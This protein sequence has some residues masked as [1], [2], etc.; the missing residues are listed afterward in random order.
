MTLEEL[1]KIIGQQTSNLQLKMP[2]RETNP[3]YE[4]DN[5]G[6][7]IIPEFRE[8]IPNQALKIGGNIINKTK[9]LFN[10]KPKNDMLGEDFVYVR[11]Q[12]IPITKDEKEM[13]QENPPAGILGDMMIG[14]G[15]N[16]L[17]DL[18][19]GYKPKT[20]NL[21]DLGLLGI[22]PFLGGIKGLASAVKN[23]N[24]ITDFIPKNYNKLDQDLLFN[25]R[26]DNNFV[27]LE[28]GYKNIP[29]TLGGRRIDTDIA[30]EL[31]PEYNSGNILERMLGITG[32]RYRSSDV[33]QGASNFSSR[34]F[35]EL[36]KDPIPKGISDKATF[37]SGGAGSGKTSS[38]TKLIDPSSKVI[39]DTTLSNYPKAVNQIDNAIK[40]H[41]GKTP[42][43]IFYVNKSPIDSFE[44]IIKRTSRQV[45][46][47]G[48]GRIV[49]IDEAKRTH[50]NSLKTIKKLKR[51]YKNN[52][53]VNIKIVDNN[54]KTPKISSL[55]KLPKSIKPEILENKFIDILTE[56]RKSD[57]I[58][59]DVYTKMLN[60]RTDPLAIKPTIGETVGDIIYGF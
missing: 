10:I 57:K 58:D 11:G 43:D 17:E 54:K 60:G 34:L 52:D 32:S 13:R 47:F 35:D 21:V 56:A 55:D 33:H 1:Q 8:N 16:A 46:E 38:L 48:S 4:Y 49:N 44:N 19:Y 15:G 29:D 9:D 39:R 41:T 30:R 20:E 42:V 3:N 14:S 27:P 28:M 31:M 51:H 37:T 26:V 36:L 5:M 53:L 23:A 40:S 2:A 24:K 6:Q 25:S 18:A 7:P 22:T 45:E 59:Q 50:S 12:P